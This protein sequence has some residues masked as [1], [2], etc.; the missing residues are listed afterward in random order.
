MLR[1]ARN[2]AAKSGVEFALT[3]DDIHIPER[4]PVLG[5]KLRR[6]CVRGPAVTSPSL[7]R[8]NPRRGYT[9]DNV[10]VMSHQANLIKSNVSSRELFR[11]AR[12]MQRHNL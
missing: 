9:A 8:L 11:I 12:W 3:R 5:I 1:N 7:D 10:V 4:C 2:R 6:N